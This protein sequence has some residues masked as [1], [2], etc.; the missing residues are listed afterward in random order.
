MVFDMTAS[1]NSRK[2]M[3]INPEFPKDVTT[4]VIRGQTASATFEAKILEH[5]RPAEYTY[6]W[7]VNGNPVQGATDAVYIRDVSEDSDSEKVYCAVSNKKGTLNTRVANLTVLYTPVLDENYPSDATLESGNSVT[8][9]AII[10]EAGNPAEY[11]YQWYKDDVAIEGATSSTYTYETTKA[12]TT[13]LHCVVSNSVGSVTT[14]KATI[15]A[16]YFYIF[17]DGKFPNGGDWGF[18]GDDSEDKG[19]LE[20]GVLHIYDQS[21]GWASLYTTEKFSLKNKRKLHFQCP[22]LFQNGKDSKFIFGVSNSQRD[23]TYEVSYQTDAI[24]S[25]SRK[26]FSVDISKLTG[27]FYIKFGTIRNE[28][29]NS[30]IWVDQIYME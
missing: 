28:Y 21:S 11:T 8:C 12:G 17:K 13:S 1:T 4:T 27:S 9:E 15:T 5:G 18:K 25:D 22:K 7:Y 23:S 16:E 29:A 6:Q 20:D 26:T 14:R 30:N 10:K 24:T 19:E 2:L 3:L